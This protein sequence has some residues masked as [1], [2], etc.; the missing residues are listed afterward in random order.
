MI[1]G[2]IG[3]SVNIQ[4][5]LS[6]PERGITKEMKTASNGNKDI[7]LAMVMHLYVA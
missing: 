5:V 1:K 2:K 6:M 3:L 4:S 7:F